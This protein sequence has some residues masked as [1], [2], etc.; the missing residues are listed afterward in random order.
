MSQTFAGEIA[1]Q[2]RREL[3]AEIIAEHKAEILAALMGKPVAAPA[4]QPVKRKGHGGPRMA[5]RPAAGVDAK[6]VAAALTAGARGYESVLTV[7]EVLTEFPSRFLTRKAI[8]AAA[9]V[10]IGTV[11]SSL[12]WLGQLKAIESCRLYGGSRKA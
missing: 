5:Y 11:S 8:A 7:W 6:E 2:I 9:G 10:P 3:M 12:H 4:V 1:A